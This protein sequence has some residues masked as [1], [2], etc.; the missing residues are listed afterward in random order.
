[1][2]ILHSPLHFFIFITLLSTAAELSRSADTI[3]LSQ[4]VRDNETLVSAGA[5]FELGFFGAGNSSNRYVGIWFYNFPAKT[6]VWVANRD[7][8]IN[9]S[10]GVLQIGTGGNLIIVDGTGRAVWGSIHTANLTSNNVAARLLDSGNLVLI[11][12]NNHGSGNFLWQSFDHPFDTLLAGMKLGWD[13]RI[14]LNRYLTSW[15]DLDDPSTGDITYAVEL[16]GLPQKFLRRNASI[17]ERS[18]P[19]DGNQFSGVPMNPNAIINP[20]FVMTAQEVY[21]T[22]QLNNDSTITRAVL[23]PSGTLHRCVWNN[24]MQW[25]VIYE[26]PNDSCDEYSKCGPNA[27]CT[28]GDARM[29]SCLTG[30]TPKSPQEWAM[31]VWSS[32]CVKKKPL[33]CPKG[34]GFE[35][36]EGVKVPDMLGYWVNKSMSLDE[37]RAKCLKNC[38]CTAYA[39]ADIAG[40]GSGCLLWYGDLIDIRKLIQ[41]SSNQ[42]VFIRV[43][44]SDLGNHKWKSWLVVA[45]VAA[46]LSLAILLL[47]CFWRRR[48]EK[49][50]GKISEVQARS[51]DNLE[52]P[53]LDL[54]DITRATNSF[55]SLNKIGEGGFG[56]VY[57]GLTSDGVQIAVKRLS[58]NS[59]QGCDEF[60][61]EVLLIARLQHR[62]LVKLL[63]CCIDGEERMLV[64]E[65]MPNG[66]LDSLI[67][68]NRGGNSLVWRWRFDIIVGVARG[69]LYLH[70]DSRLRIIH[71][72]LKASNVL[73]DSEMNPK[74]SD[75]GMARAF[76][77]D[78][79]LEKTKRVAGTY[80]YM[81]PEYAIDGIFSTK[82][83]VFSFGVL[84]LEIISGRRNREFHHHDHNFN[85]LGHAWKLWLQGKAIELIDR[86]MED[87]FPL[88]EVIRCIQIGLLCVQ[89][90]PDQRPTMSSVL[91]MLDSESA[92][93]P[94]PKQPGFY[95][96]RFN[97]QIEVETSEFTITIVEGR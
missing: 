40:K 21:Y 15:R 89:Q 80:G 19:W 6:I 14:G 54:E 17:I 22:Y 82:S 25:T 68:G 74:I 13:L 4:P 30:Y 87:S 2:E 51:E 96:E 42:N 23:S 35:K 81:S 38:T 55:S 52:L 79:L 34:E 83:D 24:N 47:L 5:K 36:L 94:Q 91:L 69:L 9:G 76:R 84:V 92:S 33:N 60:K 75:F 97:D 58:Q 28:I 65:Y 72:D 27:V 90:S 3:T 57:K 86:Q 11:D 26:L 20:K 77:R 50:L 10:S 39:Q 32:G 49:R 63:G 78:Q 61:N 29:C 71:R 12:E 45:A 46:L 8:P 88:S 18:G 59:R 66:S 43:M 67:F 53:I 95:T 64:Y 48:T 37:C 93:L 62:N 73:L 70:R 41:S 16:Q 85:L 56:P 1:M 7:D 31:L 44:A